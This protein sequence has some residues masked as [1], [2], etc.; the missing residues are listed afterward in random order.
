MCWE[1]RKAIQDVKKIETQSSLDIKNEKMYLK[2][3]VSHV[4]FCTWVE[5]IFEKKN[6]SAPQF[7]C[8]L[9]LLHL[10]F[11]GLLFFSFKFRVL[12]RKSAKNVVMEHTGAMCVRETLRIFDT[13]VMLFVSW[14]VEEEKKAKVWR[15]LGNS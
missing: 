8:L 14:H 11:H 1:L 7:D 15:K 9:F 5:F 10:K 13:I 6:F 2:I 3:R 4:H 12:S